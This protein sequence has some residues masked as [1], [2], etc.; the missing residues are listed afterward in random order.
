MQLTTVSIANNMSTMVTIIACYLILGENKTSKLT[1]V[2]LTVAFGAT[3]LFMVDPGSSSKSDDYKGNDN[4]ETEFK[5]D[6]TLSKDSGV[7][8]KPIAA[9][10]FALLILNPLIIGLG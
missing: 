9:V 4:E 6:E 2:A 5:S 10:S 1:W 7:I 3:L 8:K